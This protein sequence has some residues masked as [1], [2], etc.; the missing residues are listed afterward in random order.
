MLLCDY[1]TSFPPDRYC[2]NCH[3]K[4]LIRLGVVNPSMGTFRAFFGSEIN[5]LEC[6][7]NEAIE[8]YANENSN[9][10]IINK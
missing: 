1:R 4:K 8:R 9:I 7:Q 3:E 2:F 5:C 10:K 6:S